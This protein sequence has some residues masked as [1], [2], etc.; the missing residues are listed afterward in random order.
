MRTSKKSKKKWKKT[1]FL[2]KIVKIQFE[3][4]SYYY[5]SAK[6]VGSLTPLNKLPTNFKSGTKFRFFCCRNSCLVD[7]NRRGS[8]PHPGRDQSLHPGSREY[9]FPREAGLWLGRCLL[10]TVKPELSS[11]FR[12]WL[13][14][15][16]L[17]PLGVNSLTHV[18]GVFE[19]YVIWWKRN[20]FA[21]STQESKTPV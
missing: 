20:A 16:C 9:T 10:Q 12:I 13:C 21:I 14:W 6:E 4:L 11:G 17:I 5:Q 1:K 15:E 7:L 8:A 3:N 2:S 19:P 18:H